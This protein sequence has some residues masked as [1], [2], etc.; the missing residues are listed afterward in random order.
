VR[1]R[2]K[3]LGEIGVHHVGIAPAKLAPALPESAN[4]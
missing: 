2:V 3:G 4:A 1:N